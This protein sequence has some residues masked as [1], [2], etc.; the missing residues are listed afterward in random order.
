[1][2]VSSPIYALRRRRGTGRRGVGDYMRPCPAD[3]LPGMP[4]PQSQL[5]ESIILTGMRSNINLL[6]MRVDASCQL[7]SSSRARMHSCC[8]PWV[9]KHHLKTESPSTVVT[10]PQYK[11]PRV[12]YETLATDAS[13][14]GCV[15]SKQGIS[16]RDIMQA[17]IA[18]PN[19]VQECPG[20]SAIDS[21]PHPHYEQIRK[22]AP[23]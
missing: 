10:K 17:N 5:A 22:S 16:C 6:S 4:W 3:R 13:A 11:K 1:M 12:E 23:L 2:L 15:H 20:K 19:H 7:C 9:S 21:L 18:L 8:T 14:G